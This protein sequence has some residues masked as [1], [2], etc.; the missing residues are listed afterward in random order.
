MQ[1]RSGAARP[2]SNPVFQFDD[3]TSPPPIGHDLSVGQAASWSSASAV[4]DMGAAAVSHWFPPS[5]ARPIDSQLYGG[6]H[7]HSPRSHSQA[8]TSSGSPRAMQADTYYPIPGHAYPAPSGRQASHRVHGPDPSPI[9]PLVHQFSRTT[10]ASSFS[11]I[12]PFPH[13]EDNRPVGHYVQHVRSM[14]SGR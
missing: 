9:R 10:L 12:T 8:S 5:P 2:A 7:L 4:P 14:S 3:I 1:H 6:Q 11:A 13:F